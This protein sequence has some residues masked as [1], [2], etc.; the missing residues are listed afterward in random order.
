MYEAIMNDAGQAVYPLEAAPLVDDPK[1]IFSDE[2]YQTLKGGQQNQ[3]PMKTEGSQPEGVQPAEGGQQGQ[4]QTP[5]A[6]AGAAPSD[7]TSTAA[8]A[9]TTDQID[10]NALLKE[11]TGGKYE[12]LEDILSGPTFENDQSKQIYEL[13]QQNKT[14]DVFEFLY[15]QRML[16]GSDKL[17]DAQKI[18]LKMQMENPEWTPQDIEDE[19]ESLYTMA[20]DAEAT[21][22]AEKVARE[23][24]ALERRLKA[25]AKAAAEFFNAK[26]ADLKLP[27]LQR[28]APAANEDPQVTEFRQQMTDIAKQNEE[29]LAAI[30]KDLSQLAAIDLN[31]QLDE[32]VQFEHSFEIPKEEIPQLAQQAKDYW[33]HFKESYTKDG[34][35]QA[36]KLLEDLYFLNNRQKI[37]KSAVTRAVNEKHIAIVKTLANATDDPQQIAGADVQ[38]EAARKAYENFLLR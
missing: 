4:Q 30:D 27:E 22:P 15:M 12:K 35:W 33:N 13:L 3:E 21:L 5:P 7:T 38:A 37:L 1:A 18:K 19:Y 29:F 20:S 23:K 31:V 25:D 28:A 16:E 10:F 24:R 11:K 2:A 36:K 8:P 17:E 14:Q 32:G 9:A 6:V 34:Q 26:K